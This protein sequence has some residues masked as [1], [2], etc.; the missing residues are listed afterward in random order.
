[1]LF[2][3]FDCAVCHIQPITLQ[4]IY[5]PCIGTV[6]LYRV[7][8][9]VVR[10]LPKFLAMP[11]DCSWRKMEP[12]QLSV[13]GIHH[14]LN[15]YLYHFRT[16]INHPHF[17]Y[18][19]AYQYIYGNG[20]CGEKPVCFLYFLPATLKVWALTPHN[21]FQRIT[22]SGPSARIRASTSRRSSMR[23]SVSQSRGPRCLCLRKTA[24]PMSTFTWEPNGALRTAL[25]TLNIGESPNEDAAVTLSEILEAHVP[26]EFCLSQKACRGILRRAS[27]RG[28]ELPVILRLALERQAG[29]V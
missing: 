4:K 23:S 29:F 14:L 10:E 7:L 9:A 18:S 25:S 3:E 2:C 20:L 24:G 13:C 8:S 11:V 17:C 22:L 1:M 19:S 6:D 26:D 15:R 5:E 27:A 16:H 21:V 12:P 28:K